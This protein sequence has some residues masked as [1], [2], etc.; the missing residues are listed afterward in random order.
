MS[1]FKV[2]PWPADRGQVKEEKMKRFVAVL[3][4]LVMVTA[5]GCRKNVNTAKPQTPQSVQN[6]LA[7]SS[8]DIAAVLSAGERALEGVYQ[9]KLIDDEEARTCGHWLNAA[10][11]I[12]E[13][14]KTRLAALKFVD[15]SNKPQ[16]IDWTNQVV[17]SLNTLANQGTF[18]VTNPEAQ[19]RLRIAFQGVTAILDQVRLIVGEIPDVPPT[20]A[21]KPAQTGAALPH[22]ANFT[23]V[24]LEPTVRRAA[25]HFASASRREGS[26]GI[27]R[28]DQS[29][30]RAGDSLGR[31][32]DRSNHPDRR[33]DRGAPHGVF[34]DVV[35]AC[36]RAGDELAG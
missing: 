19:S 11:Q 13:Q 10:I 23:E 15:W 36:F 18:A 24:K 16:I 29:P 26:G 5:L 8:Y 31:R 14:Y 12:N 33:R 34:S 2:L 28:S 4:A 9:A 17:A 27:H 35:A 6:R 3:I 20:P 22:A 25:N 32:A 30:A 1:D 7:Q 21:I